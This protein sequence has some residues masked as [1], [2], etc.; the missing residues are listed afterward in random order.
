MIPRMKRIT[1][2]MTGI[3]LLA[4]VAPA[5]AALPEAPGEISSASK[6]YAAYGVAIVLLLLAAV[7]SFKPSRRSHLD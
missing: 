4:L 2:M 1:C 5:M 3:A 6:P 7:V